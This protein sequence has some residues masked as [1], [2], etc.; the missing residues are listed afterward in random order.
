MLETPHVI[1]AATIAA[2]TGNPILALSLALFSH[3]VLDEVPHWN[4]H[5]GTE[6]RKF[7]R[8]TKK[9]TIIV[10]IDSTIALLLGIFIASRTLP[11]TNRAFIILTACFLSILPDLA[12]APYFF[13]NQ[14]G[15]LIERWISIQKSLQENTSFFWGVLTQLTIITA[16][17]WWIFY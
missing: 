10:T 5:L 15:K 13:L 11:D 8:V 2:K 7:G 17:L 3:F 14:R 9:T 12:E 1:V 16:A 4:P 6:K